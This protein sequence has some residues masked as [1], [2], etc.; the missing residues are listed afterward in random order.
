MQAGGRFPIPQLIV[1]LAVLAVLLVLLLS[2]LTA[3]PAEITPHNVADLRQVV[4]LG[5]GQ[6]TS[7]AWS[8]DGATI[9]L[10]GSLGI[11]IYDATSLTAPPC[12]K[13]IADMCSM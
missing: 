13:H 3:P 9:A 6:A 10:G 2:P 7:A 8:P 4:R 5:S 12:W 1:L 11:W